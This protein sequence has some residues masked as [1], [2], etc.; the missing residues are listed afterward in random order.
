MYDKKRTS[1]M[2]TKHQLQLKSWAINC[3]WQWQGYLHN[4]NGKTERERDCVRSESWLR[5]KIASERKRRR[6]SWFDHAYWSWKFNW[7]KSDKSETTRI[8]VFL[9]TF[10]SL[11]SS[12]SI[13]SITPRLVPFVRS[14]G[15][16]CLHSSVKNIN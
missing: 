11:S 8:V 9:I 7:I 15:S 16:I 13:Q 4:R 6:K 2:P 10:T 14:D 1:T 5:S 3:L 12:L